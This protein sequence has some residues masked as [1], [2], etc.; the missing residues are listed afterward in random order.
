[1]SILDRVL[2]P[3][4]IAMLARH[5]AESLESLNRLRPTEIADLAEQDRADLDALTSHAQVRLVSRDHRTN[6]A[7]IAA[8]YRSVLDIARISRGDFAGG[9][10]GQVGEAKL[11]NL[12]AT[13]RRQVQA[14]ANLHTERTTRAA[15]GMNALNYGGAAAPTDEPPC[16][17]G[18]DSAV[19]PQAYLVDL[20][21]YA[22]DNVRDDGTDI[23]LQSLERAFGQPFA[24]LPVD[25]AFA[26][27]PVRQVRLC[28]EMLHHRNVLLADAGVQ[29]AV[30]AALT[31]HVPRAYQSLLQALGVTERELRLARGDA[32]AAASLGDRIGI[33]ADQVNVLRLTP[34]G[35]PLHALTE[36]NLERVFGLQ[37]TARDPLSTGAKLG[38]P[39]GQLTRWQ[40]RGVTWRR[41]TD[42]LGRIHVSVTKTD[43][44]HQ[45][46]LYSDE[47]RTDA[48]LVATGSR[49]T[50][51]GPVEVRATNGS[52]LTGRV[53]LIYAADD[54]AITLA[55]VPELVALQ[56]AHL[57]TLWLRAD[58][59]PGILD[60]PMVDPDVVAE[61]DLMQPFARN[62]A[63]L[64]WTARTQELQDKRNDLAA[65]PNVTTMLQDPEIL[66]APPD[67]AAWNAIGTRLGSPSAD[68]VSGAVEDLAAL[69]DQLTPETF[70]FL[71]A[72]LNREDEGAQ[73]ETEQRDQALDVL[74]YLFKARRFETWRTEEADA[75]IAL[76]APFFHL[77]E[78]DPAV[79]PLRTTAGARTAWRAQ[80]ERGTVP[81]IIDPDLV[82]ESNFATG[83]GSAQA[84]QLWDSRRQV[85]GDG[86]AVGDDDP[87]R[88]PGTL[89]QA[90]SAVTSRA[91]LDKALTDGDLPTPSADPPVFHAIGLTPEDVTAVATAIAEGAA[92]P[93][94]PQQFGLTGAELRMLFEV[95]RLDGDADPNDWEHVHHI[96]VQAEKRRFLHPRWLVE[97]Q[98]AGLSSTP[99]VFRL[100][101]ATLTDLLSAPRLTPG[102]LRWRVDSRRQVAWREQLL[103]RIEQEQAIT[104]AAQVA[105]GV[106]EEAT[107][108]ALRDELVKATVS[109][110]SG[111]ES[112]EERKRWVMNHLLVNPFENGCRQS[113]RV[114]QAIETIQLLL[115]GIHGRHLE[116][117]EYSLASAETFAE[118]WTWLGSYATWRS[119]MFTSLYPENL[120]VPDLRR[121]VGDPDTDPTTL[122]RAIVK[123]STGQA[124][125]PNALGANT[126]EEEPAV[127]DDAPAIERVY[128]VLGD[129]DPLSVE[130]PRIIIDRLTNWLRIKSFAWQT[131]VDSDI[132]L[133]DRPYIVPPETPPDVDVVPYYLLVGIT[134]LERGPLDVWARYRTEA[135][136]LEDVLYI[137]LHFAIEQY[138]RG[139]FEEALDW[140]GRVYAFDRSP[141]P[142]MQGWTDP[143]LETHFRL[144]GGSGAGFAAIDDWLSDSLN[145]HRIAATRTGSDMR[146]VIVTIIGC[147][148]DYA[149]SEFAK[150]STESVARARELY[151]TAR[152]L[153]ES[154]R[155]GKGPADCVDVIGTLVSEVGEDEWVSTIIVGPDLDLAEPAIDPDTLSPSARAV[156]VAELKRVLTPTDPPRSRAQL[157]QDVRDIVAQRLAPRPPETVH[158][159]QA[160]GRM[161]TRHG[162]EYLLTQPSVF[163][164]VQGIAATGSSIQFGQRDLGQLESVDPPLTSGYWNRA[165]RF[166]F[167]IPRNPLI[168]LL[169]LR[170]EVSLSKL[171]N[172]MNV[173]GMR[174]ELPAY[175]APTDTDSDL[176]TANVSPV[177][178]STATRFMPTHYRYRV[179][180]ERARQLVAMAQQLEATYLSYLE[181][182]DQESYTILRARQDLGMARA[183]VALQDRRLAEAKLGQTQALHQWERATAAQE[184]YDD[185]IT[186]D[187]SGFEEAAVGLLIAAGIYQSGGTIVGAVGGAIAAGAASGGTAAV[188]GGITG[189][190]GGA[191]VGGGQLLATFSSVASMLAGFERRMEEWKFQRNLAEFDVLIAKSQQELADARH[192]IAEQEKRISEISAAN[193]SD[194]VNFLSTKFTNAELYAWMSGVVGRVYSNILQEATA[195]A[196]LAQRQLAFERQQPE[197]RI[198]LD[199]YWSY[200]DTSAIL[201]G[202]AAT[203]DRRGMTGSIRLLQDL[204]RLDQEAFLTDRRTQQLSKTISLATHDPLSFARF[205]ETGELPFSTSLEQFDRQD[206]S[207]QYLRL[208]K[209]L[210]VSVIAL[211]PPT[212]G[213]RATL[214]SSGISRVVRGGPDFAETEIRRDPETIAFT[215]PINATGTFELQEQPEM[216][217]PFEGSGV[218]AV[219]W[220]FRMDRATNVVDYRTIADVLVTIDYTALDSDVLEKQV[221][222]RLG[223]S[224]SIVR[225]FSFR[226]QFA[227]A[228]YDLHNPELRE[229][230]QRMRVTFETGTGDFPPNLTDLRIQHVSLYFVRAEG[231]ADSIDVNH[232]LFSEAGRA[233][234]V[235]GSAATTDGLIST[236]GTNAG[237]WLAMQGKSPVS[238]WELRLPDTSTTRS[239][240]RD[241]SIQDVVVVLTVTGTTPARASRSGFGS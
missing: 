61:S 232:L 5:G 221:I 21:D 25:C 152:R 11:A 234:Q 53:E 212:E 207:G 34:D 127:D 16:A 238:G 178:P 51:T 109:A 3:N 4:L 120:L 15:N 131:D 113:T 90:V 58:H 141:E 223:R 156:L 135:A 154:D 241:G 98:S 39:A 174:R 195:A 159:K 217:L 54:A 72:L 66:T 138:R 201:R 27:Q 160:A 124:P 137:P 2:S 153:L 210:R 105:V 202:S 172:C 62:R 151:E 87:P 57:R 102:F 40:L 239:W 88:V 65:K 224:V 81:P 48:H 228:W 170:F 79:N 183:G 227:D 101:S 130:A 147:L 104:V 85:I 235:G 150:D 222:N 45:V 190:L 95:R 126:D 112:L 146:F 198:V 214:S 115:W 29:A 23:E 155:L 148:L 52:G 206:F 169:T 149:D 226:Q 236:R 162:L 119:A 188:L 82:A 36:A 185:L 42:E 19:S 20:L 140:F 114:A 116:N 203:T 142:G 28:A 121:A 103:G 118:E 44:S 189:A 68:D 209:R 219:G 73:V 233:G 12:H 240:F 230:D 26:T 175:A 56:R 215:T 143:R 70:G 60:A 100:P 231:F 78:T 187:L 205:R 171:N 197:L 200:S 167:C 77:T 47:A 122:F 13:A 93:V 158:N 69:S 208:V 164:K 133:Q 35:D 128:Q 67:L 196:R 211:V 59:P 220:T 168:R 134:T 9:L 139:R 41:S 179:L 91:A 55:A 8:G 71:L 17:C 64:L 163:E 30:D 7:L 63:H 193:A 145:P 165:P 218:A 10:E 144:R 80:L 96:L 32:D 161:E 94:V 6:R 229:P 157:R 123:V 177:G 97:E 237:S 33:A 46:A 216:L 182:Q 107:L 180:V 225:A 1:M 129:T 110:E 173:A 37:A 186:G 117:R 86:R 24:A 38:N 166:E 184:H 194:A 192:D 49:A 50:A 74:L 89:F 111:G 14:L 132:Y 31:A 213:I 84:Y 106:A 92:L 204:T 75:G 136:F 18:C 199:D 125:R 76:A 99:D 176:P 191:A 22:V 43:S 83:P 181:K 108:P